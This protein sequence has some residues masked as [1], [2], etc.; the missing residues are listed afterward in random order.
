[1]K[2]RGL[3]RFPAGKSPQ[4]DSLT[5]KKQCHCLQ[6]HS[7]LVRIQDL[8]CMEI[9][10]DINIHE[11]MEICLQLPEEKGKLSLQL[12]CLA[13]TSPLVSS[14]VKWSKDI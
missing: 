5:V 14:T 12:L 13:F 4:L 2:R 9:S 11:A 7:K 8:L 10:R 1:M 6:C 3:W